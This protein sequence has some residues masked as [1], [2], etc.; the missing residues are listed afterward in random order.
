MNNVLEVAN[1]S[2]SFGGVHAVEDLSFGILEGSI[3]SVIGPN[4]AGK[5]TLFNMITGIYRPST[6][7]IT[8]AGKEVTGKKPHQ[9][10]ALGMSRTFQNLQ[11]CRSA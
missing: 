10:A 1:L 8:L 4:G 6:G 7:T 5:T 3:H 9:L 11:I 2:K